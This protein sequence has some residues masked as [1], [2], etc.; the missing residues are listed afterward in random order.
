[1]PSPNN[2]NDSKNILF[3]FLFAVTLVYY[4]YNIKLHNEKI[5]KLLKNIPVIKC[6]NL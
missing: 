1:M 4:Y 5:M 3:D 2:A 6:F